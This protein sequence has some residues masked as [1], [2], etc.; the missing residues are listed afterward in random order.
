MYTGMSCLTE[1]SPVVERGI[2]MHKVSFLSL[3]L[4]FTLFFYQ[5]IFYLNCLCGKLESI[6]YF[7]ANYHLTVLQMIHFITMAL[8]GEGYLNFMGNEVN[9][10]F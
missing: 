2:A 3:L 8:G 10:C 1:A 5:A 7:D 9:I 4:C 6:Y